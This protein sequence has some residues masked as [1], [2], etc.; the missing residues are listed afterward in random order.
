MVLITYQHAAFS[1]YHQQQPAGRKIPS[2]A[3][4][5]KENI[6]VGFNKIPH[7]HILSLAYPKILNTRCYS[8]ES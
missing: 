5:K 7:T 1:S 2:V 6:S 8:L 3:K 4:A